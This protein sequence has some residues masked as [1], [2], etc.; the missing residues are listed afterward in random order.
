MALKA[1]KPITPDWYTPIGENGAQPTRFK[2]RGLSSLERLTLSELKIQRNRIFLDVDS[3]LKLF[4]MA[5]LD[6][7]NMLTHEGAPLEFSV[8]MRANLEALETELINELAGEILR[9]SFLDP[10]EKKIS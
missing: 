4:G 10:D 5:L 8:D 2:L 6:W 3:A 1:P 7:E 9:L